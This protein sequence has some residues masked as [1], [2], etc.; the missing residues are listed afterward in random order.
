MAVPDEVKQTP[1]TP[2]TEALLNLDKAGRI[3]LQ[4]RLERAGPQTGGFDGSL[5]PRS[6]APIAAWQRQSGIVETTYLTPQQHLFLVVQTD[7]MM[8]QVR[9]QY[10]SDKAA[11]QKR[12][13]VQSRSKMAKQ[14]DRPRPARRRRRRQTTFRTRPRREQGGQTAVPVSAP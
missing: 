7:P 2:E 3:D 9:A 11:A 6:R 12:Q 14:T 8:A 4:L 10:E 13:A 1:G 5:G